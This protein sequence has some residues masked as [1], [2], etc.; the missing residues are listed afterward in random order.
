MC[1]ALII[2][3]NMIISRAIEDRL[4]SLGFNSFD[5]TWTEEQAVAAAERRL[6]DLVVLGDSIEVGSAL[7]AAHRIATRG[8]VPILMITANPYRLTRP[9]PEG[10]SFDGPFILNEIEAAVA[11]ARATG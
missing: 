4:L 3:D 11:L 8:N 6:P 1:H 5:H 9:F 7:N 2:D 10:V